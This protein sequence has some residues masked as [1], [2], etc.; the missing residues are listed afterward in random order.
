MVG[1]TW[2]CSPNPLEEWF[3]ELL[4]LPNGIPCAD[5]YRRVL[6]RLDLVTFDTFFRKWAQGLHELTKGEVDA[7]DG[8]R[9]QKNLKNH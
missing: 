1:M 9:F 6:S 3:R 5:T 2:F 8:K 7:L 4:E